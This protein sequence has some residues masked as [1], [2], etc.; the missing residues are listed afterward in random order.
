VTLALTSVKEMC[1]EQCNGETNI[2]EI[3][4]C[5][6]LSA[7]TRFVNVSYVGHERES[8]TVFHFIVFPCASIDNIFM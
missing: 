7:L 1:G 8:N 6:E 4:N 2:L 3:R 5:S